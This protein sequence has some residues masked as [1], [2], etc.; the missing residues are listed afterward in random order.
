[1][2]GLAS[3]IWRGQLPS[4]GT[5]CSLN[6]CTVL[7]PPAKVKFGASTL[8]M[9]ELKLLCPVALITHSLTAHLYPKNGSR[10]SAPMF[11]E[12]HDRWRK[13]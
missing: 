7:P 9:T 3:I 12:K 10:F 5:K 1:M 13:P 11:K 8:F 2:N 6:A 4:Y